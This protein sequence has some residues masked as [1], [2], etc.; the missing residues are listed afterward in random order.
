MAER[1]GNFLIK[2][3]NKN[4]RL[5][6][7]FKNIYWEYIHRYEYLYENLS[8]Q[9]SRNILIDLLAYK[10]LG[11]QKHKLS[12]NNDYYWRLRKIAEIIRQ[13]ETITANFRDGSLYLYDLSC[14]NFD[15]KLYYVTTGI[16]HDF[17][18]EQYNYQDIVKVVDGDTVID[19]GGC[20]GDTALYFA[21][22]GAQDVY[23]FEFISS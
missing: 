16:L 6:I 10:L 20:W 9:K 14:L 18:L 19:A 5:N 3:I 8:D 13:P 11:H 23:T 2:K 7:F 22:L 21:S 4:L 1:I 12:L 17:I 15:I